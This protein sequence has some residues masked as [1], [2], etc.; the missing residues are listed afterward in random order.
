MLGRG[1]TWGVGLEPVALALKYVSLEGG[2]GD[3]SADRPRELHQLI[4]LLRH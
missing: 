4:D 2:V 1:T 3:S